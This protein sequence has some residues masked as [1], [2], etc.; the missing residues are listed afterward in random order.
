MY[1]QNTCNL[2]K[3]FLKRLG[4]KQELAAPKKV[5]RQYPHFAP[6]GTHDWRAA[7]CTISPALK[8][9]FILKSFIKN[10]IKDIKVILDFQIFLNEL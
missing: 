7:T 6:K 2:T 5:L 9:K 8:K 1:T 4:Q 3:I 10:E